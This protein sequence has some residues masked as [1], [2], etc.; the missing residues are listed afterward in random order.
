MAKNKDSLEIIL[1]KQVAAYKYSN[2][3]R[4]VLHEAIILAGQPLFVS[5]YTRAGYNLQ[6]TI[7]EP[8]R[9][10]RPPRPEEYP[11]T[12]YEFE[13]EEELRNYFRRGNSIS[14]NELYQLAKSFFNMYVDQDENI[15]TL[16]SA[17]SLFTYF[18]D[19][20]P[21]THY[22]EGVG[23]NDVGKS[24]IGYT[25]AYTGYRVVRGTSI[26]GP[27]YIRIL[28]SVEPGQ[29][30]I[31]EDESD[32]IS[33]DPDKI[34]ILKAGYEYDTRI[35]KTNMNT[36]NQETNWFFPFGYKMILGEKSINEWKAKGLADR[37][38]SFKCRPGHV[39]YS[40]K[41]VVSQTV[42]K[43]LTLQKFY[44][45]LVNF[46]KLMLCFRLTHYKDKLPEIEVNLINRD[47]ELTHPILQLF[48]GTESFEEIKTALQFFITKRR[49]K[50]SRSIQAAI[51]PVV[52]SFLSSS[53]NNNAIPFGLIWNEITS[54]GIKGRLNPY[55]NIEY[56]TNEYGPLY[57]NT[58]SKFIADNFGADI[59]HKRDGSIL[60]FNREKFDSYNEIYNHQDEESEIK[61]DVKLA[62]CDGCDGM[63]VL[64]GATHN[65]QAENSFPTAP[66]NAIT[67]SQPSRLVIIKCP[68]EGC[69]FR[70]IF[71]EEVDHHFKF[72][73]GAKK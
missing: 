48:Y 27:N 46:R 33:E 53:D 35:P 3:G 34:R 1:K 15:I 43:S 23:G 63:R 47:L 58:L 32:S 45:D 40:I 37:T 61:I 42:N 68:I 64:E 29:C 51:Y 12:A 10:I 38:L 50:R 54:G 49:D 7:E 55:N 41:K 39:R 72:T 13:D 18:Q 73:H 6:L 4:S 17:D 28:G 16:L 66:R 20:F 56:Q 25:F 19:L 31:I 5:W 8:T 11:Y 22:T 60:L 44:D 2:W 70:N 52:N 71:Q 21:I 30:V 14:I 24:S 65:T 26:S 9:T 67:P 36:K 59:I 69:D 57:M 62:E